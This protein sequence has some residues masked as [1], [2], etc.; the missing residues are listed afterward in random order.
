MPKLYCVSQN[1]VIMAMFA[2]TAI[3]DLS[4]VVHRFER[5]RLRPF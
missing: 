1:S 5:F 4:Q 2:M 3:A